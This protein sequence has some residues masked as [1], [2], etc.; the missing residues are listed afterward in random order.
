MLQ[1]ILFLFPCSTL[2]IYYFCLLLHVSIPRMLRS[3]DKIFNLEFGDLDWDLRVCHVCPR[4]S[5]RKFCICLLGIGQANNKMCFNFSFAVAPFKKIIPLGTLQE[6]A[7]RLGQD[8]NVPAPPPHS[9]EN[10]I[11]RSQKFSPLSKTSLS[12]RRWSHLNVS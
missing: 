2:L 1:V 9:Q 6:G 4:H 10:A 8:S 11:S 3:Q 7:V 5:T 12:L